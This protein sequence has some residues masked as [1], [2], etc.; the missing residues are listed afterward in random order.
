MRTKLIIQLF[1]ILL[2][3]QLFGQTKTLPAGYPDRSPNLDVLP[4]F[5]NPPKGYGEVS[6]YWWVGDTL[7]K[8]RILWQLDQLRKM[9]I[10]GLQINYCHSD[11]GGVLYGLPYPS[12]PRLFSDQ[13]WNL[14]QW[15]L[16][17]AQKRGMSVSL[18]DYT[19]SPAGQGFYVDEMLKENPGMFGAKLE[20]RILEMTG[21]QR[22]KIDIP[23]NT[24]MMRAYP[25]NNGT[26]KE[27][28]SVD[29]KSMIGRSEL[30]WN[31]PSGNWKIITVYKKVVNGSFDPMNPMSGPKIA[32]KFYQRFEEHCPGEAGKG[33]NFFFSD[34]LQFGIKGFLWNDIFSE[35]FKKRKGYDIIPELA[36]LF[37]NIG[38]R[39][40]KVRL[41]YNDVMVALT[42]E[43]FFKPLY[44]WHTSRGMLFGC[45]HG[46]RGYDV[47]E[48]GDYFRTQRWMSG[49]GCDQPDLSR[50]IIK[51]KVA[52][53]IAHMYERPRTWLEGFYASGW[54]TSCEEVA[55][56]TFANFA[57]GQN[58][59]S[60]H[61][62]YYSTH[63]SRWEWAPP[64][65]HWRQ[66]YWANMGD[67][68]KCSE[69]LSYVLSQGYHRCDV[70][71]IYPVAPVEANLKGK[72]STKT[73]FSIAGEIYPSGIDFDF[74][75][76]ESLNR[77]RVK[78]KELHVSGEK[79]KVLILTSLSAVRYSTI[80]KALEF[81]RAGGIVLSVGSLPEASE[82]I[83]GNDN[84]LQAM[85]KEMFGTTFSEK[86]DTTRIYTCRSASGGFGMYM[87]SPEQV[88]KVISEVIQP[89]F[90]ILS[91]NS[92]SGILHRKVGERDLYFVYGV[93][94]G[95]PCFFRSSGKVELWDPWKGNVSP[96]KVLLATSAGTTLELPLEKNEPQLIVFSPGIA[97]INVLNSLT[98]R[99]ADTL[100]VDKN[101]EFELKPTLDN[102]YGD[103][104]LPAFNEK[105]GV[106]TSEMKF[107][108]EDISSKDCAEPCF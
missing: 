47:T 81:F 86:H 83:G 72:E 59:L 14:F 55:D 27:E 61:G 46:G 71:I 88:K 99:S 20:S 35:E 67:F 34:E 13:W 29:L 6:F 11:K 106:E 100:L 87:H 69:R 53:S 64:D 8:D 40:Y 68:L 54:G 17:E 50:N 33:L 56:A 31:V 105:L 30:D 7:T 37:T 23:E 49:P 38:P 108:E 36:H 66:P 19:L 51:D 93:P 84:E 1:A 101:W 96:L 41:D 32:E 85:V 16:K 26:L 9:Q 73:A 12:Q 24:I 98:K 2:A 90:Q 95:T 43:G 107:A 104:R 76:F 62:L 91:G 48:F 44:E 42:E 58:L 97:E 28:A 63:G 21:N 70:A 89:D 60:L 80:E 74:M 102:K 18:S 77:C 52:S 79:Y 75:D 4:G 92:P 103:Y 39:S 45:D 65:N 10:T 78:D 3:G 25:F 22:L 94:K 15:F 57:L 5:K 82:R